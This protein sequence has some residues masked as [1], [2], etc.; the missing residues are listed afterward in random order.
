M[1][2]TFLHLRSES[3][4]DYYMA[5]PG[6]LTDKEM[7]VICN[8]EDYFGDDAGFVWVEGVLFWQEEE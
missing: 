5:K 2:I 6:R 4:D 3:G 7:D 8:D 1:E